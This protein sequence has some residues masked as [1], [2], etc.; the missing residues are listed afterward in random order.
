MYSDFT[1]QLTK[2]LQ[3]TVPADF[4]DIQ[5]VDLI[6]L[7]TGHRESM[8]KVQC[9]ML[10]NGRISFSLTPKE[11]NHRPGIHFAQFHCYDYQNKLRHV[12]KCCI[13]IQKSFQG[14]S[15]DHF[16]PLTIAQVRMALY[17]TSG[18]QNQ[19]LDDLQFS[20]VVIARCMKRAVKDWNQMPPQLATG[21]TVATFPYTANLCDGAVGYVLQ[22]A[23]NRYIRNQMRHSNAGLSMDD[24]DKGQ[25]YLQL[26]NSLISQWKAWVQ[27][28]KNQLNML[29]CMGSISDI[30]FEDY[31]W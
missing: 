14:C 7:A 2:D 24:S 17:D 5:R 8:F 23:A 18:Q 11:V 19:L 22:M 13:Q 29:Q 31:Y 16:Q 9:Q 6:C 28:K 12:F 20:D 27:T 1:V 10:Q 15:K 4:T 26:A 3:G 25:L 21:Q 30:Y